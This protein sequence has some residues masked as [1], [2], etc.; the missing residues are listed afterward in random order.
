M[1]PVFK[2]FVEDEE[3]PTP[4]SGWKPIEQKTVIENFNKEKKYS[5]KTLKEVLGYQAPQPVSEQSYNI[6]ETIAKEPELIIEEKIEEPEV[7]EEEIE[8]VDKKS[9]IDMASEYITKKAKLQETDSFQQPVAPNIPNN[10]AEINKRVRYLEQWLAKVSMDGPG[11]GEVRLKFLDDIDRDSIGENKYLAYNATTDTFFFEAVVS[12]SEIVGDNFTTN[13][14]G[15]VVSVINVPDTN[16]GP[17]KSLKYDTAGRGP[18]ANAAAGLTYYDP[19]RDTFEILHKDGTATYAGLDNYIRV[20][21]NGSGNTIPRGSLVQFVGVD[22][23]NLI[24]YVDLFK[25]DANAEPL[26]VVGLAAGNITSNSQG[27]AMLLGEIED[28]DTTGNSVNEVWATGDIL[29]AHPSIPGALTKNK[30]SAPNT[31]VSVA[32]VLN[33]NATSGHLLVRPVIELGLNYGRF[34]R[35]TN[36]SVASI[37]T[38]NVVYFDTTEISNGVVIDSANSNSRL[39]VLDSGFYQ[40]DINTQLDKTGGGGTSG[41]MYVFLRKN[42]QDV[43]DSTRR[44]GVL[45]SLPSVSFSFTISLTLAKND[46]IEIGYA[47]DTTSLFFDAAAATAFAPRTASVLVNITQIQ[48]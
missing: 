27:R 5:F 35:T 8:V 41:T 1:K 39:M 19:E 33:A 4:K 42:G 46:Y 29:W 11:S 34:A 30:P 12:G 25:A 47:G 9:L 28:I 23:A 36:L 22:S 26:Y 6:L 37:N 44:Q 16:L 10:L 40:I 13:I 32:A 20:T 24:P 2:S 21:N 7:I 14:A 17:I 45:G 38:A 48:L 31:V 3:L 15:N 43:S 18:N